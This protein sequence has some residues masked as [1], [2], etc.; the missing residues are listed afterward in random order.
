MKTSN[1]T[2]AVQEGQN[3]EQAQMQKLMQTSDILRLFLFDCGDFI[4]DELPRIM[5]FYFC[6][7]EFS[8]KER[9][10]R[11]NTVYYIQE[12]QTYLRELKKINS[13]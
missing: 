11:E 10:D 9:G 1:S 2:K 5:S 7:D 8:E 3:P 12:L 4:E 6:S 13:L